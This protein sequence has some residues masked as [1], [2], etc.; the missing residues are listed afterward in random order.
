MKKINIDEGTKKIIE[1]LYK[2]IKKSRTQII[3]DAIKIYAY[4]LSQYKEEKKMIKMKENYYLAS[5]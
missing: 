4:L 5:F 1:D 2:E 3:S